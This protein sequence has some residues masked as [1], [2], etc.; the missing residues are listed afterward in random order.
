[1]YFGVP[2]RNPERHFRKFSFYGSFAAKIWNQKSVKQ[3]SHPEQA[4][5]VTGCTAERY[6]LRHVVVQGSGCFQAPVN[7]SLRRTVA[8]LR[9]VKLPNVRTLAYFSHTKPLRRTFRWSA[10]GLH[11]RMIPISPCDSR[12]SKRVPSGRGVFLRLLVRE[13]GIPKLAQIFAYGKWLHP[14][15][16]QLQGASHLNQRYLKTRRSAVVAFLGGFPPH[17]FAPS[18]KIPPKPHFGELGDLSVQNL[19]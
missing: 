11:R 16:M 17:I 2:S 6:C 3:A 18:P 13:L 9:G 15:R 7:F 1:M 19:L 14:Y 4:I 10:H 8:E 12:R 5:Q